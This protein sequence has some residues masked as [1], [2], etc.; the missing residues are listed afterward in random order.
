MLSARGQD[1]SD[2]KEDELLL[3]VHVPP[4]ITGLRLGDPVFVPIAI[5]NKHGR[6]VVGDTLLSF[7]D[8]TITASSENSELYTAYD[9]TFSSGRSTR[10]YA[11]RSVEASVLV[12]NL[13]TP[14]MTA[15]IAESQRCVLDIEVGPKQKD[16]F[17]EKW[18]SRK[19]LKCVLEFSGTA[20]QREEHTQ[21]I[22]SAKDSDR[23][24][25]RAM[26]PLLHPVELPYSRALNMSPLSW[27]LK[28]RFPE[29]T[30]SPS[31]NSNAGEAI[32][33]YLDDAV[34]KGT[35]LSRLVL[36]SDLL[37]R[38]RREADMATWKDTI[39]QLSEALSRCSHSEA[40]F[41]AVEIAA[42]WAAS[43]LPPKEKAATQNMLLDAFPM[44]I[45]LFQ[46]HPW[47]GKVMVHP[48]IQR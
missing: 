46:D 12:L 25:D 30:T 38:V 10:P 20:F 24:E 29:V 42:R 8:L 4:R 1:R 43:S 16:P 18:Y 45:P 21:V 7:P 3:D 32:E 19:Q 28:S 14:T 47:P 15:S 35:K 9:Q 34:K 26:W 17:A 13:W 40:E 23:S 27:R 6:E 22:N 39:P 36:F 31:P 37:T 41:Y 2:P 44:H 11:P 48:W 5:R 33:V